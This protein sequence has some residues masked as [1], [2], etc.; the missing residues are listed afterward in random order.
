MSIEYKVPILVSN[1]YCTVFT[2][3]FWDHVINGWEQK[4][5]EKL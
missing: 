5:M 3:H 1:K 4:N 2:M